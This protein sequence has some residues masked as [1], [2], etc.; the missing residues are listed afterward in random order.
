MARAAAR[1]SDVENPSLG[2]VTEDETAEILS[3]LKDRVVDLTRDWFDMEGKLTVSHL[4]DSP[5]SNFAGRISTDQDSTPTLTNEL[6]RN[7]NRTLCSDVGRVR[8]RTGSRS[9]LFRKPLIM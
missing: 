9:M 4:C 1:F 2:L 3:A 8:G 5:N 6:T 7:E